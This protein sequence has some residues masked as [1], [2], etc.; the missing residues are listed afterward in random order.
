MRKL[1]C[2][3]MGNLL[4]V[5]HRLLSHLRSHIPNAFIL[6]DSI[7]GNADSYRIFPIKAAQTNLL[8]LQRATHKKINNALPGEFRMFS[9]GLVKVCVTQC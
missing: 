1:H 2:L 7:S 9:G 5:G 3:L 8:L 6:M 4:P